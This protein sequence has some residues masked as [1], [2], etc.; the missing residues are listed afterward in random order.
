MNFPGYRFYSRAF[1]KL[2]DSLPP[3]R[4]LFFFDVAL[5]I[6]SVHRDEAAVESSARLFCGRYDGERLPATSNRINGLVSQSIRRISLLSAMTSRVI[7]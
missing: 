6:S 2:P 1:T 3:P 5:I 7:G 4:R